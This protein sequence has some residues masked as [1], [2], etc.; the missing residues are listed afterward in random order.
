MIRC[1]LELT[2]FRTAQNVMQAYT[3][4]RAMAQSYFHPIK[5]CTVR[6]MNKTSVFIADVFI[7]LLLTGV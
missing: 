5:L 1:L 6:R 4:I 2:S 3:F 7:M